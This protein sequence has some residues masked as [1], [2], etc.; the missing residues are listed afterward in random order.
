MTQ[1]RTLANGVG[2][3]SPLDLWIEAM[4]RM[5]VELVRHVARRFGFRQE[6]SA[7]DNRPVR[8]SETDAVPGKIK[9]TIS[10]APG[11]QAIESLIL[12]TRPTNVGRV[13][14]KD[15]AGLSGARHEPRATGA[16]PLT[17]EGGGAKSADV[18]TSKIRWGFLSACAVETD[19]LLISPNTR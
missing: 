10:A 12:R 16:K 18:A 4:L 14:S 1:A 7:A 19:P 11:S 8:M 2:S 9:E 6:K 17:L 3:P 13:D 5:F 15:E